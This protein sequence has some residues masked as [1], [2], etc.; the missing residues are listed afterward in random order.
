MSD[1]KVTTWTIMSTSRPGLP[2]V[3]IES[4]VV[5]S[6]SSALEHLREMGKGLPDPVYDVRSGSW[7]WTW[8]SHL[9]GGIVNTET[10]RIY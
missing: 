3:A 4:K 10:V 9:P 8:E 1:V 2:T 7:R 6:V 5:E